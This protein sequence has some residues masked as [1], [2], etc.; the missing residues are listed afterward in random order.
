MD[1]KNLL[2]ELADKAQPSL[3]SADMVD[4]WCMR[5][6]WERVAK[7]GRRHFCD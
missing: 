1:M 4:N 2:M 3:A 6:N 5:I 7:S